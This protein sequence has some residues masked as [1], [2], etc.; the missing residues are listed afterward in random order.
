MDGHLYSKLE[1][2]FAPFAGYNHAI[3]VNSGTSALTL[4]LLSLG[5][6]HGDEVIVPKFTMAAC[7]WAVEY[8]GA[9]P[10]FVDCG[11]DLNIDVTK[12]ARAVTPRTKAIM[13]V[14]IYGRLCD[15]KTIRE[16]AD[17]FNLW[18][19]EDRAEAHGANFQY[20][21]DIACYSLYQNKIVS[22][23][24]GGVLTTD[25]DRVNRVANKFKNMNFGHGALKYLHAKRA[26]NM[27]MPDAQASLAIESLGEVQK[28]L[29]KRKKI[30]KM[31]TEGLSKCDE[32]AL[33]G[34]REVVWVYDVVV[35]DRDALL[36]HLNANNVD[37]RPFF[38]PLDGDLESEAF[39][40]FKNGLYLPV[41]PEMKRSEVDNIIK[42]IIGFYETS[43]DRV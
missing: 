8:L 11:P 12:I 14:H 21:G 43:S 13:P 31:Y 37:A 40:A 17:M 1:S 36:A 20:K 25:I 28:N 26:F 32:V 23:Q 9:T 15:M 19:I 2:L 24:E 29:K 16:L 4:G 6:G 22:S 27:R 38:F 5:I 30:E 34:N 42:L 39:K 41:H 7:K 10:V 35:K 33:Y 3:T 18:V